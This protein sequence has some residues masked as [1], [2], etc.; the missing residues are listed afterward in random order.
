MGTSKWPLFE[1]DEKKVKMSR[2]AYRDGAAGGDLSGHGHQLDVVHVRLLL[3]TITE[4]EGREIKI[5]V[6]EHDTGQIR[7]HVG[8]YERMDAY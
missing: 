6:G 8:V 5:L 4:R 3:I 7:W 1:V 2:G